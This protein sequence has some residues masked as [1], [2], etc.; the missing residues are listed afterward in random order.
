MA[1]T[2][3][4]YSF[5]FCQLWAIKL[6]KGVDFADDVLNERGIG[7]NFFAKVPL[8]PLYIQECY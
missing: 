3:E 6:S 8:C 2:C 4:E 5:H 7:G 1:G